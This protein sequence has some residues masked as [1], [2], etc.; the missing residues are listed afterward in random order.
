MAEHRQ[1]K[2]GFDLCVSSFQSYRKDSGTAPST[3]S[4][5]LSYNFYFSLVHYRQH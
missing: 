3:H 4:E 1:N 5:I 2:V